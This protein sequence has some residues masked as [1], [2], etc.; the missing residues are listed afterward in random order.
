M[1]PYVRPIADRRTRLFFTLWQ[2]NDLRLN[3]ATRLDK[4][5]RQYPYTIFALPL[6]YIPAN[7]YYQLRDDLGKH[8]NIHHKYL[9]H[10]DFAWVDRQELIQ[11]ITTSPGAG[12]TDPRTVQDIYGRKQLRI[13]G[14]VWAAIRDS[15]QALANITQLPAPQVGTPLK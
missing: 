9:E 12:P 4:T 13:K 1:I 2:Q 10:N 6:P 7:I 11:A 5:N 15:I 8:P 3:Q 14:H